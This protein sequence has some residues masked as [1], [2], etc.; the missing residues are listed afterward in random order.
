[1]R[2]RSVA[3]LLVAVLLLGGTSTFAE[4]PA[5]GPKYAKPDLLIEVEQLR[6]LLE[7][8]KSLVVLDTRSEEAYRDGHLPTAQHVNASEWKTAFGEG[9]DVDGWSQRIGKQGVASDTTVVVYDEG[10]TSNS[11]RIWWLLKYWGIKD[12]RMVNGG[13][14]AWK[15]AGFDFSKETPKVEPVEFRAEPQKDRL[16]TYRQLKEILGEEESEHQIIDARTEGEF[17]TGRIAL[18]EH[19]DWQQLVRPKTGKMRSASELKVLFERVGFDPAQ[20]GITYCQSGGRSSVMAFALE[21]MGGE[22]VANYYGSWG[23]WSQ[24][25]GIEAEPSK[26][27]SAPER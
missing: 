5:K 9:T 26:P 22:Q 19:L 21:L 12:V 24:K 8:H 23:E 25:E 27:Q 13:A 14:N 7:S 20:P 10:I 1:M 17:A 18:C 15:S 2:I 16:V 11:A 3:N 6:P 4:T